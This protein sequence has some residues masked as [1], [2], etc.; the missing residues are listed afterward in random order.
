MRQVAAKT[1][2]NGKRAQRALIDLADAAPEGVFDLKEIA[3]VR[4]SSTPETRAAEIARASRNQQARRL[5]RG[6]QV[7]TSVDG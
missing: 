7:S 5:R 4:Y 6:L 3:V 1:Q 2:R